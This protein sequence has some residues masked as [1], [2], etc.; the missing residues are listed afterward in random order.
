MLPIRFASALALAL[1]ASITTASAA[2]TNFL[3]QI[4]Q[5]TFEGRRAGEGYFSANGRRL[6]FQSEREPDNPF[7][8]IYTL[9]LETGDSRR[10]S[11]GTGKTTCAFLRPGT[12]EV[13][14]A[15]THLDARA[16]DKQREENDFR[17]SGKQ[18][19]YAWDYDETMDLFV[20][21]PDGSTL[22]RLTDAPGYDAEGSYS[23]DGRLIVFCSLRDA[24]PFDS[25]SPADAQRFV[26]DPSY[27]GEIYLMNADGSGQRRLTRTPG[28]DGGPFFSPDGRR[29]IWRRFDEKGLTADVYTM[30]LDGSDVRRLTDFG[31]MSWAPYFHP[32]GDYAIFTANK[33]GFSNFE[34]FLVDAA[35][36]REPVRVTSTDGFDGLPVFSPDGLTLCWTSARTPD[37]KSQLFLARWDH[38]AALTALASAPPRQSQTPASDPKPTPASTA[39][40]EPGPAVTPAAIGSF[41]PDI[42]EGDLRQQVGFLAST[43]L[44][45]R[46]TGSEGARLAAEYIRDHLRRAGLQPLG[47][48][49]FHE[50]EFTAGTRL[51]T[52][53]NR[54][55]VDQQAFTPEQDFRPLAFSANATVSGPVV[56]AGYGLRLPGKPGEGY[57][58]Y[59][60][61]DVSNRIVLA[62]RYVPEDVAPERRQELNRYAGL[63]Y[64][65]MIARD[66][67]ARAI[68]FVTGP[69][70]PGTGELIPLSSDSSLSGSGILAA[71]I[72]T[73]VAHA[74]LT[75][76]GHD[77]ASL[78]AALDSENPHATGSLEL[79]NRTVTLTTRLEQI[80]QRDRNVVGWIP[81]SDPNA[82]IVMLGAHYD[83]LGRGEASG[84]FNR[85]GEEGHVCH[86]A[87]DNA[88]GVAVLLEIAAHAAHA[89][90]SPDGP[91]RPR[92]GVAFAFWS[93]EEMGLLGSSHF[94]EHPPAGL[95][96]SNVA[97]YLNFDMVGR[98]RDNRLILQGV[99]SST[100]WKRL[101]EKRNVAA[102]FN[103][104]LQDDP[105][106]P[107]DSTAF[108]P[109]R[110]P[111]LAFFTGS[112][113]D[114]HRPTDR[115]DTLN[116]PGMERIATFAHRLLDD[117]RRD[118][119][120]PDYVEVVRSSSN[121][122]GS[123][124]SLRA[125]L[126]TIPDYAT[127][128]EGVKLSGVRAGSPAD[129]AGI[130]GG[131]VI[132]SMAGRKIG[133]IYDYTYSLD[134][135][136]IGQPTEIVVLR[137][138]ERIPLSITPVARK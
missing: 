95:A 105:Y 119:P 12:D 134:A 88:S 54:L 16:A 29:I 78:Q 86:G 91:G 32:S 15:S 34:L 136:K 39:A 121:N 125:Y 45:G 122:P 66:L 50:F 81:G 98:L 116:Y 126:G 127:E 27:F 52:N 48:D 17:A 113:E 33:L 53:E 30:A 28:Y 102:G 55:L 97:A 107:T 65:A 56:F 100:A 106:L 31:A 114:Y 138:G 2:E 37:A 90:R 133:N 59:A 109:R 67:G 13:L 46:L 14:F 9:D 111:I 20:A 40:R 118:D 42:R 94:A 93:G 3:S 129:Q 99:G 103:A 5:L 137:N 130:R 123:R 96:I 74:L 57:D 117:L 11:P 83:H 101:I 115:H 22:R 23:P 135:V 73:N 64:K 104:I 132:V 85:K 60:G 128:I 49:W 131:D 8:Q 84:A 43:D 24:Y 79:T 68:L 51:I 89:A 69:K 26:L 108:Y 82:G 10:V 120:R 63:R 21:S 92:R 41:S 35:G 77:L 70:S 87:D 18:R 124:D 58:S 61:L 36:T 4:R 1:G 76:S 62:L 38:A 112:H 75:G 110:V 19:R 7:Y 71:S 44:A 80:R 25:L 72:T 6:V 47:D